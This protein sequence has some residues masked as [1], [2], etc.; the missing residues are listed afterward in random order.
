MTKT[1]FVF[2]ALSLLG[3]E[4][5]LKLSEVVQAKKT[6]M[7][8]A[9]GEELISW[10]EPEVP[11]VQKISPPEARVL[12]FPK[13]FE[14]VPL[15][16][17]PEDPTQPHIETSELVLWQREL[18]KEADVSIQ[19]LD[20]FKGYKKSTEMYVVKTAG[21]DG[22]DKIRFASTDGILVDKKQA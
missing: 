14:K 2:H 6:F 1:P 20:A 15:E 13:K 22:K 7:K 4:E 8:K 5:I 16:E 10:E 11:I 19:K 17:I 21:L 12:P 3:L 18:T 9:A